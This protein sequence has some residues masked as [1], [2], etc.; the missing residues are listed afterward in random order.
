M[1]GAEEEV[2]DKVEEVEAPDVCGNVAGQD[3]LVIA[4][5]NGVF[6]HRIQWCACLGL[7]HHM[8]LFRHGLFSVSLVHPKTAFTFDV[9]EVRRALARSSEGDGNAKVRWYDYVSTSA[10]TI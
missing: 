4:H 7:P 9:G 10:R 1:A 3:T 6:H 5:S 8:Q 2:E